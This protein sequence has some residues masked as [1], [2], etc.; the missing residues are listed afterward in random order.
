MLSRGKK[1]NVV[2][3]RSMTVAVALLPLYVIWIFLKQWGPG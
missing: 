3:T 2:R 1:V